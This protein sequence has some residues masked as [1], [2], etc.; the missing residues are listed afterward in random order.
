VPDFSIEKS[1]SIPVVGIDEVGRGPLAGPVVSCAFIFFDTS[2]KPEDLFFINDSKKLS[3]KK[4]I[5]ATKK[6]RELRARKKINFSLGMASVEEIDK[7]NILEATKISMIRA[8]NNLN[9]TSYQLIID[10][11][12]DLNLKNISIK[13]FIKGDNKSFSIAAASIIAKTYRDRYMQF[14]SHRFPEYNWIK[15]S[16]YGT[17]EHIQQ[18]YKKGFSI[19]HRK[20]FE[21]I[22]SLIHNK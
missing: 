6:I 15:N 5:F 12:I 19:H 20:S 17:K 10:G 4:R 1:F 11:N 21:P 22:K 2:I 8:I 7:Y 13:N 16:G 9:L 3:R 18:I 14:L